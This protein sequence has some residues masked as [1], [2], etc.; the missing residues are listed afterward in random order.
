VLDWVKDR[1][2][3][4]WLVG[5]IPEVRLVPLK[6]QSIGG[7][8]QTCEIQNDAFGNLGRM[9]M[10]QLIPI[11]RQFEFQYGLSKGSDCIFCIWEGFGKLH[12][13]S[14]TPLIQKA[15][16]TKSRQPLLPRYIE[17]GIRA[18]I[19][20]YNHYVCIGDVEDVA[21]FTDL[22]LTP[23][24][25]WSSR[26]DWLF[27]CGIDLAQSSVSGPDELIDRI[28]ADVDSARRTIQR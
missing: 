6:V 26:R 9:R 7:F 20:G 15:S 8:D 11:L 18:E 24:Y 12:E 28:I 13:A 23:T 22:H 27:N 2:A 10:M 19:G 16:R 3:G 1:E 5:R 21:W 25:W 14:S 4:D 17:F